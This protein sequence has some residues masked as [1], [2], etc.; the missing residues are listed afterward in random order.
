MKNYILCVALFVTGQSVSYSSTLAESF[1]SLPLHLLPDASVLT[2]MTSDTTPQVPLKLPPIATGSKITYRGL[3]NLPD[4]EQMDSH[5]KREISI[6]AVNGDGSF[7][8]ETDTWWWLNFLDR[9]IFPKHTF[10]HNDITAHYR[11]WGETLLEG[12]NCAV[13][14]GTLDEVIIRHETIPAC[15]IDRDP[16]PTAAEVAGGLISSHVSY[17]YIEGY[18]YPAKITMDYL[19]TDNF[20]PKQNAYYEI[21]PLR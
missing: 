16:V 3:L 20:A 17:Y 19:T 9:L 6:T 7:H 18:M 12:T 14:G 1:Q 10:M 2:D 4:H 15:R 8:A 21:V 11:K 13:S 5:Y